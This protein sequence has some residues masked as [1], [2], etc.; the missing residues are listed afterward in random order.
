MN[1]T[2]GAWKITWE[3]GYNHYAN[4]LG[5]SMPNTAKFLTDVVRPSHWRTTYFMCYETLTSY[6]TP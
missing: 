6:G 3:I 5:I 2:N 4:R 1:T